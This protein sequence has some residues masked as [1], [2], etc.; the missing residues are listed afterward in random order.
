MKWMHL[1]N[2]DQVIIFETYIKKKKKK[3][4]LSLSPILLVHKNRV[5]SFSFTKPEPES[6]EEKQEYSPHKRWWGTKGNKILRSLNLDNGYVAQPCPKR[7]LESMILSNTCI[8]KD[9]KSVV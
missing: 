8:D 4:S 7:D 1:K 5:F 9:R 6:T 2:K 3:K